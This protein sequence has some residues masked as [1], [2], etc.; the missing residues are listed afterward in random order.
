MSES[1][2]RDDLEKRRYPVAPQADEESDLSPALATRRA[3]RYADDDVENQPATRTPTADFGHAL[4]RRDTTYSIHS[5]RSFRTGGRTIDPSLA[6][7]VTYRTVSFT[8]SNTQEHAAVETRQAKDKATNGGFSHAFRDIPTLTSPRVGH[9]GM[10]S[11]RSDR[12]LQAPGHVASHRSDHLSSQRE[13]GK[14]RT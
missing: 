2:L 5:V 1:S 6:L 14:V 13:D 9:V 11:P 8:I 7:P 12:D 10:A 3:I 4:S